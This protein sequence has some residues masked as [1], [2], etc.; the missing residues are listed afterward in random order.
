MRNTRQAG[1]GCVSQVG[2][3][4]VATCAELK[5]GRGGW[6]NAHRAW[7]ILTPLVLTLRCLDLTLRLTES[8]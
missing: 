7:L 6:G 4:G 8:H 1:W 2:F 3:A 5:P